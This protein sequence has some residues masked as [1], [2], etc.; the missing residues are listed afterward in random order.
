MQR[1]LMPAL[2]RAVRGLSALFWGLPLALL[3]CTRTALGDSWR[4]PTAF[5]VFP[6]PMGREARLLA[7]TVMAILPAVASLG[8]LAYGLQ[9]LRRFQPQERIW[10]AA[11]DRAT[12]FN[13]LLMAMVPFAHWWHLAPRQPMFWQSLALLVF[14]GI[15]YLLCLNRVLARLAA[16]LPDEVLRSDTRLFATLNRYLILLLGLLLGLELAARTIG[17]RVPTIVHVFL[18]DLSESR[19]WLLVLLALLPVALTMTLLWRAKEAMLASVY[20]H[21]DA[22]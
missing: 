17:H 12:L 6:G 21:E 10:I 20:R 7:D 13:L 19:G 9:C 4:A 15:C 11:L 2:G 14:A 3:A 22:L 18:E 8:L 5:V 16:L 1:G